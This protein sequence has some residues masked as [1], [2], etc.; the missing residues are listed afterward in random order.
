MIRERPNRRPYSVGWIGRVVR[1]THVSVRSAS[2]ARVLIEALINDLLRS[3]A[4]FLKETGPTPALS[5]RLNMHE[6]CI[7]SDYATNQR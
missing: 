7:V 1:S 5:M 6:F 2:G 4:P 3:P